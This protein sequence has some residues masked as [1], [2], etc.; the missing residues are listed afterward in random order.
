MSILKPFI[1]DRNDMA[2]GYTYAK[3][4]LTASVAL[5]CLMV[6]FALLHWFFPDD[7]SFSMTEEPFFY[8]VLSLLTVMIVD[9][10][11]RIRHY[12]RVAREVPLTGKYG[13]VTLFSDGRVLMGGGSSKEPDLRKRRCKYLQGEF[14]L[15]LDEYFSCPVDANLNLELTISLRSETVARSIYRI[16]SKGEY[17]PDCERRL[18][19]AVRHAI[20]H[21]LRIHFMDRTPDGEVKFPNISDLLN[22][23][24]ESGIDI[25]CRSAIWDIAYP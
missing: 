12:R 5:L 7:Y 1:R 25:R 16:T 11:F 2:D 4:F 14:Y 19:D 8:A 18:I 6:F 3:I 20:D 23:T 24:D 9:D 17:D 22:L 10:L 13:L 21:K 15:K